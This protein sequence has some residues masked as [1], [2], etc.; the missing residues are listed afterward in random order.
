MRI[1]KVIQLT[2][3]GCMAVFVL[4]VLLNNSALGKYQ[5][6]SSTPAFLSAD[7]A[8]PAPTSST[9]LSA[10]TES[11]H[12]PEL[13]EIN[14]QLL[15]GDTLDGSLR[16]Q[17]VP[18]GIRG[19]IINSLSGG[20]V[21]LE[22]LIDALENDFQPVVERA[23]PIVAELRAYL[24]SAGAR[25]SSMSGSGSVVY[26]SFD[27]RKAALGARQKLQEQGYRSFLCQ[28]SSPGGGDF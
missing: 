3:T 12:R 10:E 22:A 13:S 26:G 1:I 16:R 6:Q 24:D 8:A 19:Q 2:V 25:A 4:T 28:P 7:D 9:Q 20:C 23:Y 21:D 11:D 17:K 5:Q 18:C 14:G 27:D 15:P